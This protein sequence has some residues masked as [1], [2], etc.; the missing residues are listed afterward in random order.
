MFHGLVSYDQ[1]FSLLPY[2][3][4]LENTEKKLKQLEKNST[5][6]DKNWAEQVQKILRKYL[7]VKYNLNFSQLTTSE[8]MPAFFKLTGGI[9]EEK[10][11][12]MGRMTEIFIRTDFIRYS[13]D[14][15]LQKNEKSSL[16]AELLQIIM[17]MEK[18]ET[19]KAK[20]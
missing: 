15:K 12:L 17:M 14:A 20:A 7:T 6:S 5:L 2:Y 13:S 3:Y 11:E 1:S 10:N 8:F 4:A 9:L 18:G 16:T 19:Y